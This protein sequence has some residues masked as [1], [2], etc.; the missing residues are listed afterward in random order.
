MSLLW[1]YAEVAYFFGAFWPH[2]NRPLVVVVE[3]DEH[4]EATNGILEEHGEEAGVGVCSGAQGELR[5]WAQ[6][7]VA[8]GQAECLQAHDVLLPEQIEGLSEDI[9]PLLSE[10]RDSN[11]LKD[12]ESI[13]KGLADASDKTDEVI[14]AYCW[15]HWSHQAVYFYPYIYAEEYWV[16]ARV[17]PGSPVTRWR[18]GA[19]SFYKIS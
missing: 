3:V 9:Q 2:P 5:L 19:S 8:A 14:H 17:S 18:R 15:E 4:L 16:P 6:R 1:L 10:V 12:V 13:A 11:L 7:V